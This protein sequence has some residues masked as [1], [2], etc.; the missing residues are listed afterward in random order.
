MANGGRTK[1]FIP[2]VV[3][4]SDIITDQTQK[5]EV[6]TEVYDNL[7]GR[8]HG[9]EHS[10]DLDFLGLEALYLADLEGIFME[11]GVWQ[12]IKE[13]PLIGHPDRMAS[14]APFTINLGT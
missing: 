1:N 7:L 6:F 8:E 9:R 2:S 13:I 4:G 10:I 3:H 12:V 5:E 14:S 11:E